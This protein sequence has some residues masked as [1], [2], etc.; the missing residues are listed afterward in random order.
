VADGGTVV[1]SAATI[2]NFGAINLLGQSGG[3][4]ATALIDGSVI[5]GGAGKVTL[6]GANNFISAGGA[7]ATLNNL[8]DV[9]VGAGQIG[10]GD[11]NL[12]LINSGI[13]DASD[14]HASK[15]WAAARSK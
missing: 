11:N 5:L 8:N 14:G 3:T 1:L 2:S 6:S 13:I 9:I 15:L 4:G 7:G 10:A 12:T